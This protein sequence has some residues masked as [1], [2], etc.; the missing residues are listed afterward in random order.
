MK[1][2]ED[3]QESINLFPQA[4]LP[5]QKNTLKVLPKLNSMDIKIKRQKLRKTKKGPEKGKEKLQLKSKSLLKLN[6]F[7]REPEPLLK[8]ATINKK[9]SNQNKINLFDFFNFCESYTDLT[10]IDNT[11]P[12]YQSKS[13]INNLNKRLKIKYP[14][15]KASSILTYFIGYIYLILHMFHFIFTKH[16]S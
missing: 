10:I 7:L 13:K 5:N 12:E 2:K 15:E 3:S 1:S 16:V 11:S 6:T 8:Y 4:S 9:N 14:F